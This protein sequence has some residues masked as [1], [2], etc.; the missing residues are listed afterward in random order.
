MVKN[1][2][3]KIT[4]IIIICILLFGMF[5]DNNEDNRIRIRVVSNSNDYVDIYHKEK[6]KDIVCNVINADDTK[7]EV[8]KK[9][10][11]VEELVNQYAMNNN[12]DIIVE[13]GVT[14]F[15]PKE[16]NGKIISGGNY[17]TLLV[18]IG[19]GKGNNYWTL[20]YPEYFGVTFEE[21]YSG[22][23]EIR[24]YFYDLINK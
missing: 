20:L 6:V 19:Q 15:P 8:L 4:I 2:K 10:N 1:G 16:L 7:E 18:T 13:F 21:I 22:D 5:M 3:L 23:V 11:D 24:S 17:E 9:L 12:L 14:N